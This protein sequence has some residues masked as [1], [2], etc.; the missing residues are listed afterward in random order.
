MTP[1]DPEANG[2]PSGAGQ[3]ALGRA[4][5]RWPRILGTAL[6]ISFYLEAGFFLALFPWT[7][8][9]R[10]FAAFRPA[11]Q[12]YWHNTCVRWAISALGAVNL[13]IGFGELAKLQRR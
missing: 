2:I 8:Y 4:P 3:P 10:D 7:H 9:A 13:Y 12:P 1:G 6:L 5:R 11:W